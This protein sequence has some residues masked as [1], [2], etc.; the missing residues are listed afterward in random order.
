MCR[1]ESEQY[2]VREG[3]L[4]KP[5]GDA[6][7]DIPRWVERLEDRFINSPKDARGRPTI[8]LEFGQS[9]GTISDF[10]IVEAIWMTS[11][12]EFRGLVKRRYAQL[13]PSFVNGCDDPVQLLISSYRSPNEFRDDLQRR[14]YEVFGEDIGG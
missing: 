7:F 3:N 4:Q 8:L 14:L 5:V 6:I 11:I 1:G 12:D 10:K 9:L 13:F 2:R